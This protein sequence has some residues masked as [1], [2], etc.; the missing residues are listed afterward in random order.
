MKRFRFELEPI[1]E[2]RQWEERQKEI[3]LGKIVGE[4]VALNRQIME[5][6]MQERNAFMQRSGTFD[7]ELLASVED[8]GLRMRTEERLLS[9]RLEK[10]EKERQ[11]AQQSFLEAS[12]RRKVLEKLKERKSDAFRRNQLALEQRLMDEIGSSLS[13]RNRSADLVDE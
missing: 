8:Y 10:K 12:R 4:C 5:R 9:S 2:L 3:V 6:R 1:L 7:L 13:A 11:Q